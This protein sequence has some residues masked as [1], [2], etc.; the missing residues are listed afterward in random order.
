MVLSTQARWGLRR[1]NDDTLP[2]PR[3]VK[4]IACSPRQNGNTPAGPATTSRYYGLSLDLL[5]KYAACY[6]NNTEKAL[7]CGSFMPNDLGLFDM[8]GNAYE[9]DSGSQH[10][11][12]AEENGLLRD[13]AIKDEI[14]VDQ[15]QAS[16]SRGI[17]RYLVTQYLRSAF[18]TGEMPYYNNDDCG[19][20]VGKTCE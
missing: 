20:R 2:T 6:L 15:N 13:I 16:V 18:R 3:P 4:D 11:R 14:V 10:A 17:V 12:P 1:R 19:F 5:G 7:A 8:L 9:L